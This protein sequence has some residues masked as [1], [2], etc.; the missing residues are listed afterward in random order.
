MNEAP[1]PTAWGDLTVGT[2]GFLTTDETLSRGMTPLF[3]QAAL[4]AAFESGKI[5]ERNRCRYPECTE[6]DDGKCPRWL[7]GECAGPDQELNAP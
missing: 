7:T 6:N 2:G 4:D 3:D 1:K 5:A